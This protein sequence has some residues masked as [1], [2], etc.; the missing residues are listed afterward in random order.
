MKPLQIISEFRKSLF[1]V[2]FLLGIQGISMQLKAQT[3]DSSALDGSIYC[4]I[5]NTSNV[6]LPN[7]PSSA[8][9][10]NFPIEFQPFFIEYGITDVEKAFPLVTNDLEISKIYKFKFTELAKI[11]NLIRDIN[12]IP[13]MQYAEMVPLDKIHCTSEINFWGNLTQSN[14][15]NIVNACGAWT[16][17]QGNSPIRVAILD[18]EFDITHP[19]LTNKIAPTSAS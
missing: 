14:H 3:I 17:N 12:R 15:L 8:S 10:S 7:Y 4:K 6:T 1:I 19:D 5:Q 16:I 9:I 13:Y 2:I 11:A 18:N